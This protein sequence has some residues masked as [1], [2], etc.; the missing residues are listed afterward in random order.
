MEQGELVTR[1]ALETLLERMLRR[2]ADPRA[3]IFGPESMTWRVNREAALFLG[4][5]RAALLQLAHPWVAVALEQ[6]SSLMANPIARFHNTFRVVFTMV[7]GSAQ[8]ALEAARSLHTLHARI[9]GELPAAVG[10][11]A[12][13][14]RYEANFVPALVWVYAT[15]IE[16]AVKA[17][18][19]VLPLADADRA[20][21]YG[22]SKELAGL[23]GIPSSA[24]PEDWSAFETYMR[25]MCASDALGVDERSRAMAQRLLAGAGSWVKPP[26]WYRALTAAWMPERFRGEFGLRFGREEERAA[27]RAKRWLPR[28]FRALPSP[29]RFVGPYEEARAR[30]AGRKASWRTKASNRFWIGESRLPFGE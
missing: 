28:V 12:Q 27:E 10:T 30:L 15:L 1:E 26:G 13:G 17:Y 11:Y 2:I 18:S 23:F 14:S 7:F 6:H 5:G 22:E 24:L 3:G 16:S 21:Y 8:Q 4:A 29:L 9:G 19:L 25:A 20:V